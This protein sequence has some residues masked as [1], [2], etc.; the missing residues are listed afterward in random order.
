MKERS[1]K[2]TIL[3]VALGGII[4]FG[5]IQL[6]P[7]G[8]STTNPPI[9]KEPNW[10]SPQTRALA[11]KACFDCHSN[12]TKYWWGTK[13]APASWLAAAD[14]SGGRDTLNFSDWHGSGDQGELQKVIENGSMPPFQYTI[15]HPN[16]KLSAAEKQ[17]LVQGLQ[18]T[19]QQTP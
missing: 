13:I 5:L 8:H 9:V 3:W 2:K 16:A 15:A 14:V 17:Q 7:Y 1:W 19:I 6:I 4:A 18:T 12:E 10:D 11:Q